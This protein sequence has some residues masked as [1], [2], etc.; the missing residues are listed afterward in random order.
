MKDP[1]HRNSRFDI[2]SVQSY[3]AEYA[4]ALQAGL[5]S[6]DSSSLERAVDLVRSTAAAG[7]RVYAVGNGG[8]AA[9]ADHLSCDWTKGTHVPGHPVVDSLSLTSNVALYSA[10]ANDFGFEHV[11]STQLGYLGRP[12]DLLLAISSSGNSRNVLEAVDA[13]RAIGMSIIGMTGFDGGALRTSV[14]VDLHVGVGNYGVVEDAHQALAH[15]IAQFVAVE[16]D[17]AAL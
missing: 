1:R 9:I 2:S 4:E 11:F 17:E 7:N 6:V 15:V 16:R 14:D 13:A 5:R 12:G 3:V 10:M 8:S